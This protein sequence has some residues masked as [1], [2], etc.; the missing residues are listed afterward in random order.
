MEVLTVQSV[1]ENLG[2][3]LIGLDRPGIGR[4]DRPEGYRLLDWPDDVAE[5]ADQL[6]IERFAVDGLSSGAPYALACAYKIPHRLTGCSLISSAIPGS[7]IGK[8]DSRR[9]RAALWLLA[10]HP[11]FIRFFVRLSKQR[12][13]AE[14][15]SW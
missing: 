7:F 8:A 12:Q 14:D 9:L 11:W 1:A 6:G 10:H 3:R 13:R 4:S 5:V 2:V 15:R